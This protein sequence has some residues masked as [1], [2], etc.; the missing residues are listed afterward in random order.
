MDSLSLKNK[1]YLDQHRKQ[2]K[3]MVR[4]Y[5]D[6][7][8]LKQKRFKNSILVVENAAEKKNGLQLWVHDTFEGA[9]G[10]AVTMCTLDGNNT[11]VL[12]IL[13]LYGDHAKE[14][15]DQ[16]TSYGK[17]AGIK[18]I[19]FQT[20]RKRSAVQKWLGKDWDMNATIFEK[21]LK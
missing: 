14:W 16:F 17:E 19:I 11:P 12:L 8:F 5:L 20:Y 4:T 15:L 18:K 7:A 6:K 21:R 3:K 9:K 10:Y 1:E 13:Q 2:I